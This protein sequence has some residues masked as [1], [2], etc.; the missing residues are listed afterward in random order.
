MKTDSAFNFA[1]FSE[2]YGKWTVALDKLIWTMK[3]VEF[4]WNSASHLTKAQ[5]AFVNAYLAGFIVGWD[6]YEH[7]VPLVFWLNNGALTHIYT[8]N[9]HYEYSLMH[10][11]SAADDWIKEALREHLWAGQVDEALI[12]MALNG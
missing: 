12:D 6:Y 4:G 2:N 1:R 9:P 8:N 11:Y 3:Q 10:F 5:E 7:F